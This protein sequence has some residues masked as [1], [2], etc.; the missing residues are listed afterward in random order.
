MRRSASE[1]LDM[2][3][4]ANHFTPSMLL[5]TCAVLLTAPYFATSAFAQSGG[6]YTINPSVTAGGGSASSN[7]NI[8]VAGSIGQNVLGASTGAPFS[9]HSGFWPNAIPCPF[10]VAPR[11]QF[12]TTAGG[13][14]SINVVAA[15]FCGWSA[16]V[17]QDWIVI[18]S[19]DS[20][21]G[22]E[23]I[24]FE[25]RENFT[26]NPRQGAINVSG[27]HQVVVQDA[28]LGEDCQYETT[29]AFQSFSSSGG[30]GTIS[31]VAEE[32]CA[33]QA[34]VSD[35]WISITS[36]G[37]GIGN[38]TLIYTTA[39]NTGASARNGSIIIAG[40]VFSVKQKGN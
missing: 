33:W 27:L 14:G 8:R 30:T 29:P 34:I 21:S 7:G 38:G 4:S 16:T 39:A 40:K 23:V 24:T 17:E 20:G 9:I 15:G 6:P 22:N 28:G 12:F 10:A 18:T 26:S 11:A 3:T 32:R 19:T 13:S 31:V 37:V 36:L 35:S 2:K 25:V 5:V 1:A